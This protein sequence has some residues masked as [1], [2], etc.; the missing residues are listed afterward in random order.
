MKNL[1][2]ISILILRLAA[3]TCLICSCS[4]K[5]GSAAD[6]DSSLDTVTGSDSGT[7]NDTTHDSDTA[8]SSDEDTNEPDTNED[9]FID[10][11]DPG[12]FTFLRGA[13]LR[14]T[15]DQ[16]TADWSQVVGRMSQIRLE[17]IIIQ[18][19][20]YYGDDSEEILDATIISAILDAA[21]SHSMRVLI[22]LAMPLDGNGVLANAADDLF[23]ETLISKSVASSDRIWEG[24]A[25]HPAFDG[26]YLS[27]E[28]WTPDESGLGLFGDYISQVSEHCASKGDENIAASFFIQEALPD[29]E[30]TTQMIPVVLDSSDV[31]LAILRDSLENR[32]QDT[33]DL[34][35]HVV[36]YMSAFKTGIDTTP[37]VFWGSVDS[38]DS[39]GEPP[40]GNQIIHQVEVVHEYCVSA[41]TFEFGA[42][43]YEIGADGIETTSLYNSVHASLL[44]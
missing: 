25:T 44:E 34:E 1:N 43:W 13:F 23:I 24:F 40:L 19:E 18:A 36:P 26:F 20:N 33:F 37:I 30:Y 21:D 2:K 35:T 14:V 12:Y 27:Y 41:V 8:T 32:P 4:S 38:F 6:S 3:S 22:G 9:K 7:E 5:N 15:S 42:N 10:I 39:N 16:G 29:P 11:G 31:T 28:G 17:T